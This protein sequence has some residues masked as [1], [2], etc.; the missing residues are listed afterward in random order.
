[1]RIAFEVVGKA[2]P[3]GSKTTDIVRR[4]GGAIVMRADGRPLQRTRDD[5]PN[6]KAW[7]DRIAKEAAAAM[8]RHG[9]PLI[10]G[11]IRLTLTF[12]RCRPLFHYGTG[13]N[14][15]RVRASAPEYPT[16][17]PDVLKTARAAEDA[18]TGIIYHDDAQIVEEV[19]RKVFG[20]PAG[21]QIEIEEM[22]PL[23]A[24]AV[25]TVTGS[26]FEAVSS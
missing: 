25:P 2:E 14:A 17:K 24:R 5:N 21:V 23:R 3:A 11:P 6:A 18:M 7:K 15:A 9:A 20:A 12:V 26:L 10:L 19:L 4:K 8:A 13:A 22:P 1:M 16:T